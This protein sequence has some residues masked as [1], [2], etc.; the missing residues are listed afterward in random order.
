MERAQC[1]KRLSYEM[2]F[3]LKVTRVL[4]EAESQNHNRLDTPCDSKEIQE[5]RTPL[6]GVAYTHYTQK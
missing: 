2:Y 4:G 3:M 1:R 6:A 5:L